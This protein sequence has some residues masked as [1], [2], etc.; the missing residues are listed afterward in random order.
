MGMHSS[1]PRRSRGKRGAEV[2]RLQSRAAAATSGVTT[3]EGDGWPVGCRKRRAAVHT[4]VAADTQVPESSVLYAA[5]VS[6]MV[7]GNGRRVQLFLTGNM[8]CLRLTDTLTAGCVYEKPGLEIHR[9]WFGLNG[10]WEEV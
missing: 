7:R 3:S 9:R 6:A 2:T 10:F 4:V 8:E 1:Q 5:K